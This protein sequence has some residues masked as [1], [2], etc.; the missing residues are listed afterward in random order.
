MEAGTFRQAA[1]TLNLSQSSVS[2]SLQELEGEIGAE[3]LHRGAPGVVPT[4]AGKV[5]LARARII[6]AELRHARNDVQMI[7]GAHIG[8]ICVSASPTVAIGLL[9]RAAVGFQRAVH[10]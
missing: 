1:R 9:P 2:K 6:E 5:L 8:E 3:M 4:E 10:E 7:Q